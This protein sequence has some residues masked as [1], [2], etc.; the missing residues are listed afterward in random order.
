MIEALS[1]T[2]PKARKVYRCDLYE[3]IIHYWIDD[4]MPI[5]KGKVKF[6]HLRQLVIARRERYRIPKGATYVNQRN[7][8]DGTIY[9]FRAR[10]D[11]FEIACEY[12]LL[13]IYQ[14]F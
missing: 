14:D 4:G 1:E 8:Q 11:L 2:R 9:T 12:D 5:E 13:S 3:Q 6:C 7:K 10:L